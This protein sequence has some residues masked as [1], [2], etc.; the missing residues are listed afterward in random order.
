MIFIFLFAAIADLL[1]IVFSLMPGADTLPLP[2]AAYDAVSVV[3]GWLAYFLGLAGED[4]KDTL[5]TI[6][7]LVLGINIFISLWNVLRNWR[8]RGITSKS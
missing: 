8:F 1:N 5:L 6:I 4:I 3:G 7:P 2:A